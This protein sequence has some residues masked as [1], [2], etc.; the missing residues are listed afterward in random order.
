MTFNELAKVI[1]IHGIPKD[2]TLESD[3]GWECSAT[4][5]DGAYYN[6]REN[7]IVF[8]QILS[9]SDSYYKD[10]AWTPIYGDFWSF[11]VKH[12]DPAI[13]E[14]LRDVDAALKGEM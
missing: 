4:P 3:S 2:V 12:V 9:T 5:M 6:K 14:H 8:K 7:I 10:P 11:D 1:D 13:L